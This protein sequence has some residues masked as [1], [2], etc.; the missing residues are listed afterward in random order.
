M[1]R[2]SKSAGTDSGHRPHG[3]ASEA[4]DLDDR[5]AGVA[6]GARPTAVLAADEIDPDAVDEIDGELP[7][8]APAEEDDSG[9]GPDDA[10]GLYLRQMGA[11]PLLTRD[12]ELTLARRLEGTRTR[13]RDAALRSARVLQRVLQTFDKVVAGQLALDPTIDIVTS[14]GLSRDEILKRMPHNLPTLRRLMG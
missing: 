8:D 11:I 14:L 9:H 12:Q 10:L 13:F 6:E 1:R 2:S 5:H 7:D 3:F 4:L